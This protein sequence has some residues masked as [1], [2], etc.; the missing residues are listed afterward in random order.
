MAES[1]D[2]LAPAAAEQAQ[3]QQPQRQVQ[4]KDDHKKE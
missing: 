3:Q 2:N 4:P 1:W